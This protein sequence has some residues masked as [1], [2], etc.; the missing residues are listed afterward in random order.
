MRKRLL[1]LCLALAPTA[2]VPVAVTLSEHVPASWWCAGLEVVSVCACGVAY[3]AIRRERNLA[4]AECDESVHAC[5]GLA[6]KASDHAIA[7]RKFKEQATK[8][9][10]AGRKGGG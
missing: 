2:G 8:A 1:L 10:C 3:F 9:R 4:R 5:F 6:L 7:A